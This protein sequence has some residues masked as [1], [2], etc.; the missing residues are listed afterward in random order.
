MYLHVDLLDAIPSRG[1]QRGAIMKFVR[2]LAD[3]PYQ[4][5]DYTDHDESERERQIRIVGD[6]AITY[7]VD[8]PVKT[9]MVVGAELADR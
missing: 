1:K 4:P 9:V 8:A 5:G 3:N 7:W 6:Y 2:S